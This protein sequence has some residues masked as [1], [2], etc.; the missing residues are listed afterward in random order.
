L[1]GVGASGVH[2]RVILLRLHCGGFNIQGAMLSDDI[3]KGRLK[4]AE[5]FCR[6]ILELSNQGKFV[7]VEVKL[8]A[9]EVKIWQE[10]IK[11]K[12]KK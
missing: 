4:T 2:Y 11:I 5:Q 6:R 1:G 9:G 10:K 8:E 7:D 3:D 12:P